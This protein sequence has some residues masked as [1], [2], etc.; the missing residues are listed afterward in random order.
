MALSPRDDN[1][2]R[3]WT[4]RQTLLGG[5]L[6]IGL[7][8]ACVLA[9]MNFMK[10]ENG[11]QS[12]IQHD[13]AVQA[14]TLMTHIDNTLFERFQNAAIW[15]QLEVMQDVQ[16]Q[17]V[18]KRLSKFLAKLKS[19]YGNV[20]RSIRVTDMAGLVVSSSEA[21]ELGVR[22]GGA[23]LHARKIELGAETLWLSWPKEGAAG[24]GLLIA[25]PVMSDFGQRQLGWLSLEFD[26]HQIE[27][28]LDGVAGNNRLVVLLDSQ[29]TGLAASRT[30]RERGEQWR[31][32]QDWVMPGETEVAFAH[33]GGKLSASPVMV[34]M[35]R[36]RRSAGLDLTV[37]VAQSRTIAL[38][39]VHQMAL[40]SLGWLALVGLLIVAMA[41]WT[42]GIIARPLVMLTRFARDYRE[43]GSVAAPEAY[44]G[45]R[46]IGELGDSF[47]SMIFEIEASR[48]RLVQASKL[49]VVG[50]M[51]A[52]IAHEVR[53]PLGILRSSAQ[54]LR[55]EPGLSS[56]GRELMGFIESETERLNRLVSTM[57]DSARPRAIVKR[58][59]DM[60]ILLEKSAAMLSAQMLKHAIRLDHAW[61][62]QNA[63]IW[64]DEEQ[65]TQVMLNLLLNA[66]QILK[67]GG[68]IHLSS[69]GSSE[70]QLTIEIADDGP[71]VPPM[72][73]ERIFEAFFF[74]REGGVGLGLAIV[75]KIV[76]A[77]GGEILVSDSH[78]GGAR[79][80]ITL[81]RGNPGHAKD[82]V[83]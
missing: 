68:Q 56:E 34:G 14:H 9:A 33:E 41:G 48:R 50:E 21:S 28:L 65:M 17:D 83:V 69:S 5:F 58:P 35:G 66:I 47:R 62:A 45:A 20:Y 80:V 61:D 52:V 23:E 57:L 13:L 2:Q 26:W 82:T 42:S 79:F 72:E 54:M 37:L 12:A 3:Q 44:G 59:V 40:W 11:M 67:D 7:L 53:T 24:H 55:R 43:D 38:A 27:T 70:S 4:I 10:A 73:R 51:S 60:H 64:C 74:R 22:M 46:E 81:P 75:Q 19:G 18:D 76:Q 1:R 77:H 71:G 63:V 31:Q 32:L 30:L 29:Q 16:V 36:G 15:S 25:A 78:W 49:A 8:P 6:L 39:P